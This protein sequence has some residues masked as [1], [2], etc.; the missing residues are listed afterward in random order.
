MTLSR[1][2]KGGLRES[3][4]GTLLRLAPLGA[5][6]GLGTFAVLDSAYF[7]AGLCGL[8]A[9]YAG[10]RLFDREGNARRE[11]R[12]R[13]RD[14]VALL[15]EVSR[16][17]RVAR[18]QMERLEALQGGVIESWELMPEEHRSLLDDEI[19]TVLEE[20]GEAARLARRR[21]AL[22]AN[23]SGTDVG[24]IHARIADLEREVQSL[25]EGSSLRQTFE[26]T[27]AGR[28]DELSGYEEML[29]GISLINAQLESAESL[30]SNLRG[31]LLTLDGGL[32]PALA[33]SGL[34]RLKE[35]VSLFKRSL[36]EVRY[37]LRDVPYLD[38]ETDPTGKRHSQQPTEELPTR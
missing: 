11:L 3:A 7:L 35:R 10:K 30:L 23:V 4:S 8:G 28:R 36:D 33:G 20:I 1:R 37:A 19:F 27:L 16:R 13:T 5:F 26:V 12:R 18:S 29:D 14:N 32:S 22:R 31:D 38:E 34:A 2:R 25:P 21:A 9:A 15:R 17:D 24:E 6:T